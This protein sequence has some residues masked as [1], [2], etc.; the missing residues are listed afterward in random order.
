MPA[1]LKIGS[2]I[3]FITSYDCYEPAHIH[4]V[5]GRKECKFWLKADDQIIS[6]RLSDNRIIIPLAWIPKL[7]N[8]DNAIREDY[9]LRCPFAFWESI[10]ENIG[11]II[12]SMVLLY[13]TK[14]T[15]C[16]TYQSPLQA[17][18]PDLQECRFQNYRS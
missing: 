17:P 16:N 4:G 13:R 6:V 3:F 15:T 1:V 12:C 14:K 18:S 5:N 8:A 9:I 11:V 7:E 2:V 10:D